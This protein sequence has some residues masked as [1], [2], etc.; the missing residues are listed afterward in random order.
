MGGD[1][2]GDSPGKLNRTSGFFNNGTLD[3]GLLDQ[4]FDHG[5]A[6]G[7]LRL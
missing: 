1:G 7:R 5:H 3:V 6:S 2:G 4:L